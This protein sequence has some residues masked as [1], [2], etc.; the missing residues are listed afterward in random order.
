[1]TAKFQNLQ[2]QNP[3]GK[4]ARSPN[5]AARLGSGRKKVEAKKGSSKLYKN[6]FLQDKLAEQ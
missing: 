4:S 6:R 3:R 2:D 5:T 1:M